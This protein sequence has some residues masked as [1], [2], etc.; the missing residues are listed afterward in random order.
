MA[1]INS[2]ELDELEMIESGLFGH[3]YRN[4]D[5]VFKVYDDVIKDAFG[6]PTK[7]P[8]LKHPKLTILKLKRLMALNSGI[9]HT[10]LVEDLLYVDGSFKGIVLPYYDGQTFLDLKKISLLERIKLSKKLLVNARELN[11]NNIYPLDQRVKNIMLVNGE[12]KLIDLDDIFTKVTLIDNTFLR[13]KSIKA[14]DTAVKSFLHEYNRPTYDERV[15]E[16]LDRKDEKTN[17]SFRGIEKYIESKGV[18]NR[19]LFINPDFD[20]TSERLIEPSRIILVCNPF[21][22]EELISTLQRLKQKGINVFDIVE[23]DSI[24]DYMK[25]SSYSECLYSRDGSVLTLKRD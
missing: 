6:E 7:N 25:D 8:I 23:F 1:E 5:K 24:N 3:I 11:D 4:G 9:K 2:K 13:I 18:K 10:D 17:M 16:L 14:L 22:K 20:L 21:N 12:V 15:V 19:Y